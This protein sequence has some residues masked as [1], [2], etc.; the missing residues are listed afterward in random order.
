MANVSKKP[1]LVLKDQEVEFL[2]SKSNSKTIPFREVQRAKVLYLYYQKNTITTIS[3]LTNLSRE[4]IYK[5]LVRALNFG[6][7]AALKDTEHSPKEPVISEQAKLWVV[8]LACTKPKDHGYAAE[9]WSYESL[10]KHTRKHAPK[11]GHDCLKQAAK[12]NIFRI[13]GSNKIQPQKI[14]YYLERRDKQFEEKMNEVLLV[15]KEVNLLNEQNRDIEDSDILTVSIDEK[16]GVQAIKNIAPDLPPVAGKHSRISRD[17]EYKRLG[18]LSI[19]ASLDLQSGKVIA[20]VENQHRSIEFIKLLKK[21]DE[22]Y[23]PNNKIRIILDNHSSHKSKETMEYLASR[24]N[25]FVYVYTPKHG[26]W[27][28]LVETLFGKMSRTFLKQIRVA[29][30]EELKERILKGIEEINAEPVVHRWKEFAFSN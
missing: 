4:S 15:Y 5:H 13:L 21:L 7:E 25:R 27:L 23:P 24:P 18:T 28:N 3:S 22:Y 14:K 26:S 2:K 20:L 30:K 19:L 10:A 11:E 12:A 1:V 8:T 17:Y 6:V 16:P 9:V 29:S